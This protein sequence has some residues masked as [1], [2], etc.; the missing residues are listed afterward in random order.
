MRVP[1]GRACPR[2][3]RGSIRTEGKRIAEPGLPERPSPANDEMRSVD[4][5]RRHASSVILVDENFEWLVGGNMGPVLRDGNTVIRLS[6]D[7]TPAVHRLLSQLNE[8]GVP[9]IPEPLGTTENGREVL[10]FI[11]GTVPSYPM[12][13]WVWTDVAL[14]SAARLLRQIH[15]ATTDL[16]IEG[17]W[18]S[19]VHEPVEVIC[20][21]DFATYN[22]VFD[23][24]AVVGAIDWDFASPGSRLWDLSYL[25]YRIVPL[26]T[27]DWGDGFT[28]AVRRGRVRRLLAAYGAAARP[29]DLVAVLR[30]RLHE[31]ADFSDRMAQRLDKP[32]LRDH[33][34]TYR[35]DAAHLPVL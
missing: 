6:G 2:F 12:P 26:T 17:P 5:A 31:L 15:D 8:A 21:N 34:G 32:E 23:G 18:R 3:I 13:P 22:L 28:D 27:A 9:G 10:G 11:E 35:H 20:H 16:E 25:A 19:P 1:F 30:E 4:V 24:P 14:D 29:A 7:W 33:A